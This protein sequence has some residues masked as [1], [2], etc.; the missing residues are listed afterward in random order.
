MLIKKLAI[1]TLMIFT[2]L[3][4]AKSRAVD[5][6]V[7][8]SCNF[9]N[10]EFNLLVG[11]SNNNLKDSRKIRFNT[12]FSGLALFK[13]DEYKQ[14][15][16]IGNRNSFMNFFLKHHEKITP[17]EVEI[18]AGEIFIIDIPIEKI[19]KLTISEEEYIVSLMEF[20][21][22]NS[23]YRKFSS[24]NLVISKYGCFEA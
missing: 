7:N 13:Y 10:E 3:S 24:N 14:A 4:C 8:L 9:E 23:E 19:Y 21:K 1:V 6:K 16:N 11:Y 22:I 18:K 15:I 17:F 5:V 20:V 2:C 12:D